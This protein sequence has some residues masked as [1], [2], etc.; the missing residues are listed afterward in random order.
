MVHCVSLTLGRALVSA[1]PGPAVLLLWARTSSLLVNSSKSRRL[2]V[3]NATSHADPHSHGCPSA[4]A[5]LHSGG[6]DVTVAHRR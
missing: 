4:P 6:A 1:T 5:M 2:L 3:W